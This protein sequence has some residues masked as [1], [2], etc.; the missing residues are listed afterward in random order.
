MNQPYDELSRTVASQ[1]KDYFSGKLTT[2]DL[3]LRVSGT[4]F[5][6]R[7]WS[8]LSA[9]PFGAT[10]TYGELAEKLSSSARAIGGA[11]RNN[12]TPLIVPCHRI[13]A[14]SGIGGFSGATTGHLVD[15]KQWLL[16]WESRA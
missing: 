15:T 8:A 1:V 3:P 7:V 14:A 13:V 5:R 6:K 16:D 2:F 4:E 11:C 9:I 10:L 12:P